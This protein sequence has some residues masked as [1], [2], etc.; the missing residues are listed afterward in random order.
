M[1]MG[2]ISPLIFSTSPTFVNAFTSVETFLEGNRN[3]IAAITKRRSLPTIT[4]EYMLSRLEKITP[5]AADDVLSDEDKEF[6]VGKHKGGSEPQTA[7]KKPVEAKPAVEPKSD[8]P[9]L[10]F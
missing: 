6:A 2:P 3:W 8:L 9:N 10:P 4:A 1:I 7:A 5:E